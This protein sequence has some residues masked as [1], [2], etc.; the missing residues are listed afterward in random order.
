MTAKNAES[1][2]WSNKTISE[3]LTHS[4]DLLSNFTGAT[5][6][7]DVNAI[8]ASIDQYV[9]P[10]DTNPAIWIDGRSI[11]KAWFDMMLFEVS[12][13]DITIFRDPGAMIGPA[14]RVFQGL[15]STWA[16]TWLDFPNDLTVKSTFDHEGI[17]FR[18][19][20]SP[21]WIM[22]CSLGVAMLCV[23]TLLVRHTTTLVPAHSG[24]LLKD[25]MTLKEDLTFSHSLLGLGAA[26]DKDV[27]T[28][29]SNTTFS[30]RSQDL[31]LFQSSV[32]SA[33]NLADRPLAFGSNKPWS[34]TATRTWFVC[35]TLSL[36]LLGIASFEI[37]QTASDADNAGLKLDVAVSLGQDLVSILPTVVI[38][39]IA[40][41]F[42]SPSFR[43]SRPHHIYVWREVLHLSSISDPI[44]YSTFRQ[45]LFSISFACGDG[46]PR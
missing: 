27:K 20:S 23:I 29:L 31:Q 35:A 45:L 44:S 33:H 19:S 36:A 4:G 17:R 43:L 38:L 5:L 46:G 26:S 28:H 21:F 34:P 10:T 11:E 18:I 39:T 16:E 2:L 8:I 14:T 15:A 1:G 41:L 9:K 40:M 22:E 42:N 7:D 24:L 25:A 3:P 12:G 37:V 13:E 32:L 30:S 6:T